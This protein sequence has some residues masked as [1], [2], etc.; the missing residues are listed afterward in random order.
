MNTFSYPSTFVQGSP[1]VSGWFFKS[2]NDSWTPEKWGKMGEN[3]SMICCESLGGIYQCTAVKAKNNRCPVC[4]VR[5]AMRNVCVAGTFPRA[6]F[7]D[8]YC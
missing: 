3:T 6:F 8:F 4:S 2:P 1:F 7:F 5:L